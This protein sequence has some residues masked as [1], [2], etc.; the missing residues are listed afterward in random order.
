MNLSEFTDEELV[1]LAQNGNGDAKE[2]VIER[3]KNLVKSVAHGFFLIG[4]DKEDLIIEG[5]IGVSRAV[6]TYNGKFGFG[7]YAYK[8]IRNNIINA[9]R[10]A[11]RSKNIPLNNYISLT[12]FSDSDSDTDKTEIIIDAAIDPETEYI[13]KESAE[14]LKSKIKQSLSKLESEI[15]SMYLNGDS[16]QEIGRKLGKNVKS[17]D[18]AVQRIRNKVKQIVK[19]LK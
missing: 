19:S 14:E 8:C 17:V 5:M 9:I 15:L 16:Y 13:N 10:N 12:G 18:N 3:N 4:G 2:I 7:T 1:S 6:D 11:N